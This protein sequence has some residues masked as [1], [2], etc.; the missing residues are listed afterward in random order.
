MEKGLSIVLNLFQGLALEV[1]DKR[2][3]KAFRNEDPVHVL[4][5]GFRGEAVDPNNVTVA[6]RVLLA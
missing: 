4:V 5:L 6:E 3:G 1:V 2:I